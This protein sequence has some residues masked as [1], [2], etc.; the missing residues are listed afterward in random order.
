[1]KLQF[2]RE[3][4]MELDKNILTGELAIPT[5]ARGVVIFAHG[6]GSGRFSPRNKMVARRL[7]E[8]QVGTLLL[9]LLTPTEER[10]HTNRFDTLLLAHRL[11]EVTRWLEKFEHCA[12]CHFAFFGAST[13][14]AAALRASTYLPQIKAIVSRGGRTDLASDILDSVQAPTLLI[15]GSKDEDVLRLNKQS[16]ALLNSENRL[17]VVEGASHLFEEEGKMDKVTELASRWFDKYL[18]G[19]AVTH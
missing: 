8:N 5:N 10:V 13:G 15:V 11:V 3:V 19:V 12:D 9:D 2:C 16:S 14:A 4:K 7:H 6:S 18:K 17:A 1:M